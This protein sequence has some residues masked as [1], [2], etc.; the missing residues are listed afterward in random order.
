MSCFFNLNKENETIVKLKCSEEFII[1]AWRYGWFMEQNVEWIRLYQ[2]K[3]NF[4]SISNFIWIKFIIS[5]Y[6]SVRTKGFLAIIE[7]SSKSEQFEVLD[8][9]QQKNVVGTIAKYRFSVNSTKISIK[10]FKNCGF[11]QIL[12][13]KS[14]W[15]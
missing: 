11:N 1:D 13:G 6:F 8:D 7:S 14:M 2:K 15:L 9:A 12:T 10:R 3:N 4:E 5:H